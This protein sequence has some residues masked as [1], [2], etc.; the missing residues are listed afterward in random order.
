MNTHRRRRLAI[1]F[2][3]AG[4]VP[5]GGL[6]AAGINTNVA[7]P[8]SDGGFVYRTQVRFLSA[9]D[10]PSPLDRDIETYVF[11]NVVIYG[12]T[13]NTTLFGIVPYIFR[14]VESTS[15]GA[16]QNNDTDGFGDLTFLLRQTIYTR[17]AVQR[18][19]RLWLIAGLEIPSGSEAFSSHSTDFVLGGVYTL[20]TGRHELDANLLY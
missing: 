13:K 16:R 15:A 6:Q 8:V 7:L 5:L 20:Q 4:L 2:L 18:T 10:D 19:S 1:V 12:A 3:A 14:S 9:S 17:D 11:S